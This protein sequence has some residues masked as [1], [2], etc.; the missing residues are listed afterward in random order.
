MKFAIV[1]N[2]RVEASKGLKGIC[3]VCGESVIAKCGSTKINHWAHK[4][5]HNCD[6][7]KEHETEWHREWKNCFPKE[8]QEVITT[9]K[10]TGEKHI[11][12]IKTPDGIVIEFQHSSIDSI[13]QL[14]RERHHKELVWV[15]DCYKKLDIKRIEK[16][17]I[18]GEVIPIFD[19]NNI[20]QIRNGDEYLPKKW[21]NRDV[22]VIYDINDKENISQEDFL[23]CKIPKLPYLIGP[24]DKTYLVN[25][26][27][28]PLWPDGLLNKFN[29]LRRL[30]QDSI[31]RVQPHYI[32]KRI[33][34]IRL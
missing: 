17:H 22:L 34:R 4:N 7:W 1:N 24:F 21:Y 15:V 13:E 19:Q 5:K 2:E 23:I 10:N 26:I 30:H 16:A 25:S 31:R 14:S 29:E 3:P 27:S 33:N 6:S 8:W 11:A 32:I 18:Q 28:N 12:D 20:W 9:D